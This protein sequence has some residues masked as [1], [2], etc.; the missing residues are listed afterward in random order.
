MVLKN[1]LRPEIPADTPDNFA[2]LIRRCWDRVPKNRP[3]FKQII[4]ELSSMKFPKKKPL[5][6][7]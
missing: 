4:G 1:D 7:I 5:E 3:S 6:S 2:E